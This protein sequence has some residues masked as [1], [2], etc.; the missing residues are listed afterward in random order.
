MDST[1]FGLLAGIDASRRDPRAAA[2]LLRLDCAARSRCGLR[3]VLA[4]VGAHAASASEDAERIA[5]ENLSA[6]YPADWNGAS[7]DADYWW[8]VAR[9]L[10]A[11][12]RGIRPRG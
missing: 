8:A 3:D 5:A 11:A 9:T 12:W 1:D 10:R 6:G 7:N 2:T 4:E